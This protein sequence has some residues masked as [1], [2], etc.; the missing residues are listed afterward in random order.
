MKKL[1][2]EVRMNEAARKQANPNVP[3]T[4]D[5]I[6]ADA[7][8]CADAGAA[9]VH[10]HARDADGG[11]SSRIED[12]RRIVGGIRDGSDVL[13]HPTLGRFRAGAG[14]DER[15]SHVRALCEEGLAPDIAPLDMGSNNVDQ[16]DPDRGTF[17]GD[18]FVY[19]NTTADL[20][21]MAGRLKQWGVRPQHA[22]WSI[23]DLRLAG[24]F[25]AAGLAPRPGWCTLFLAGP[26]FLA[27]HPATEAGLRAYI[28]NLPEQ[29][30]GQRMIWSAMCI[31]REIFDLLPQVIEAGGHIS[32]GLGDDPYASLG[33][34]TNADIVRAVARRVREAGREIATPEEAREIL[35]ENL[36]PA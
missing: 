17:A 21:T 13:I 16:F 7:L 20:R 6:V 2:I 34:P 25:L 19:V 31:G 30:P 3:Y 26:R 23:P 5:E 33:Q 28:D 36:Q 24:A 14:P 29:R 9:V 35:S 10:F 18:G 22:I 11:E 4:P 8:A 1:L 15:L 12:Y 27:G 32:V